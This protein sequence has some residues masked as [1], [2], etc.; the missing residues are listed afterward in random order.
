MPSHNLF[1]SAKHGTLG[2]KIFDLLRDRILNE[3]YHTGEKL[4]E[5]TLVKELNI[6]RTPIREALK[7]LE[8]EGLVES[9]PNKGV[10]V[11]GFSPR[12][13]DDMFEIRKELEALAIKMA[14]A[15]MDEIHLAKI[16]DVFDLMEFYTA[17][18]DQ[19][20]VDELNILYHETIYQA[21]QSN[22]FEQLLKD[23]HYYVSVTSRHCLKDVSRMDTA[24]EEHRAILEMIEDQDEDEAAALV[25]RHIAKT[26]MLVRKYYA[27]ERD[28]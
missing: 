19:A 24:L 8:L 27:K 17:K 10:Y 3:E 13:I 16:K 1:E 21:T 4:N 28:H 9:I 12:D 5:L 23:I 7:Q 22:Y 14:I 18:K 15:R 20:K 11:K 2:N 6:S 26:Q 25:R